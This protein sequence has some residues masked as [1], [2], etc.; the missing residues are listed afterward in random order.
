MYVYVY[1]LYED[2]EGG[3]YLQMN[4]GNGPFKSI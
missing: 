3:E 2:N 1:T 4:M